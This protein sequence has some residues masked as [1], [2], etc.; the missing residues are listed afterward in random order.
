M[1]WTWELRSNLE[2][3]IYKKND[4]KWNCITLATTTAAAQ[5][6]WI[7]Y[8]DIFLLWFK[9]GVMFVLIELNKNLEQRVKLIA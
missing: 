7:F 5:M 1:V 6:F 9:I 4:L 3:G 2:V 8:T